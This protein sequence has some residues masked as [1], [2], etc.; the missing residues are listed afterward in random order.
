MHKFY[1]LEELADSCQ[2]EFSYV[3]IYTHSLICFRKTLE[4]TMATCNICKK[5]FRKNSVRNVCSLKCKIEESSEK[6]ENG[7]WIW[8]GS[9]A[10]NYGKVR[11]QMQTLSAHRASY[12]AYKGEVPH[13]LHVCHTC[14]NPICTNPDHL[15]IGT[16]K[17]NIQ[18]AKR[19]NRLADQRGRKA[20]KETLLKLKFRKRSDRRGEKHH[21]SKLKEND[22]I[23]IRQMLENGIT[24]TKIALEYGLNQSTVCFIKSRK[25]WPHI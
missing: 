10:G 6:I 15:W 2:M 3:C 19:K 21:L 24:Q 16:A 1:S 11:W 22:V 14:D 17:E 25:L 7:C 8:Q 18:D 23:K 13:G 9:L 12:I 5:E 20:S 4:E